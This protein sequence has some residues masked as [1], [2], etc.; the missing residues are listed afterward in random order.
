MDARA[1]L[2]FLGRL[3]QFSRLSGLLH[4]ASDLLFL[5]RVGMLPHSPQ[6][7]LEK[8]V[9]RLDRPTLHFRKA[10]EN[11]N[12]A[13]VGEHCIQQESAVAHF[14]NH[15]RRGARDAVVDNPVDEEAEGHAERALD[16]LLAALI[17][18]WIQ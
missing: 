12:H 1:F 9:H 16:D 15:I 5:R 4:V 8:I 10:E 18:S 14:G 13:E 2:L 17:S 7:P 11:E 6:R 3:L